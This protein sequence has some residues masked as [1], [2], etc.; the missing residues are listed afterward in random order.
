M[1]YNG[2]SGHTLDAS[3]RERCFELVMKLEWL[4]SG[5][6]PAGTGRNA[7]PVGSTHPPIR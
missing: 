7:L 4:Q 5:Y 6:E 3:I 2:V 1:G